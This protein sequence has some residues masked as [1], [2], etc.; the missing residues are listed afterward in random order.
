M[1]VVIVKREG[2]VLG[3]NLG[4]PIVTN[5]AFA[6]QL[7]L[8]GKVT[9]TNVLKLWLDCGNCASSRVIKIMVDDVQIDRHIN[10]A[11]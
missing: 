5:G 8:R 7:T 4:H 2:A 6:I 11:I 1:E 10:S 3:V 9:S